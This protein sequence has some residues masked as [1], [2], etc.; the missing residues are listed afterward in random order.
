M[1]VLPQILYC[2]KTLEFFLFE[3]LIVL[4]WYPTQHHYLNLDF[5]KWFS[6]TPSF[7]KSWMTVLPQFWFSTWFSLSF[8]FFESWMMGIHLLFDIFK[9]SH[10]SLSFLFFEILDE[11]P[12]YVRQCSVYAYLLL[13][14]LYEMCLG[15]LHYIFICTEL[16]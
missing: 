6:L 15:V 11:P 13:I 1:T 4:F 12:C 16:T 10:G 2:L 7:F 5:L 3:I 8:L 14:S 9:L